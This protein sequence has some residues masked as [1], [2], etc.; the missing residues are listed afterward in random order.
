MYGVQYHGSTGMA[1]LVWITQQRY[2]GS[3]QFLVCTEPTPLYTGPCTVNVTVNASSSN[4]PVTYLCNKAW[5]M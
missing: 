3:R 2:A 1:G 4:Y 5:T